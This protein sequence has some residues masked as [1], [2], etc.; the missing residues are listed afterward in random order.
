MRR[1]WLSIAQLSFPY[2]VASAGMTSIVNAVSHHLGWQLALA[3]FPVMYGIH[4][5]YRVYFEKAEVT[6]PA[7]LLRAAGVGW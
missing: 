5:S 1:I 6:R 2:F 3:V 7:P 4:R